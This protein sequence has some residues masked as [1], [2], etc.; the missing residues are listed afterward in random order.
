M[1]TNTTFKHKL[2]ALIALLGIAI[3]LILGSTVQAN[4]T[5]Q[6]RQQAEK[7]GRAAENTTGKTPAAPGEQPW[8]V[9]LVDSSTRNAYDGQ[10]CGASLI[11]PQWVLTAAH[12][13]EENS[14]PEEIDAVIGR[15][16]LSSNNGDRITAAEVYIHEGYNNY[17]DGEDNDI[18][19]IKLSRPAASGTPIQLIEGANEYVDDPGALARVTGW[20]VLSD[21]SDYAP[22]K[23]HGVDVP[24]VTQ[25]I[26]K[27]SYG[28]EL[29]PD[30]LCAGVAEGGKD[31]CRGDSGGPLVAKDRNGNPIQ[32]GV[33][34]W[35]D[36]CGAPG[37]YGVYARLT[38]YETWVDDVQAGR[39]KPTN[40]EDY[41]GGWGS[42]DDGEWEEDGDWP[43]WHDEDEAI[44]DE[45]GYVD[46]GN[47]NVPSDF[48]LI[49]ND[50]FADEQLTLWED[51]DGNFIE[52]FATDSNADSVEQYVEETYGGTDGYIT[53]VNGVRV[54]RELIDDPEYGTLQVAT[55]LVDGAVIE[56]FGSLT[57]AEM[58]T[59][60]SSL[61]R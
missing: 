13:V 45:T 18:A 21:N 1:M 2:T 24:V 43:S 49:Y 41:A 50:V 12:C 35:G 36:E 28:D 16:Q 27:T 5:K 31:S 26:C 54:L 42:D 4:H 3:T 30:G 19:L 20:G 46:V 55:W 33:V 34:S 29:L 38:E 37:V 44:S 6:L 23:L 47:A 9:A 14:S 59:L 25:A 10:F 8:M 48:D 7:Q 56:I 51:F 40:M 52:L 22:D 61:T 11:A 17:E 15:Y 39:I 32:I 60:V 57:N 58:T 53:T